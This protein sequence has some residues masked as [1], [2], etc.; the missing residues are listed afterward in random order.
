MA[1]SAAAR[2]SRP[3]TGPARTA[4]RSGSCDQT[5]QPDGENGHTAMRGA[6]TGVARVEGDDSPDVFAVAD[7]SDY[8]RHSRSTGPVAGSARAADFLEKGAFMQCHIRTLA[9][10]VFVSAWWCSQVFAAIVPIHQWS[11]E[12]TGITLEDSVG[13]ADGQLLGAGGLQSGG[14]LTLPGG[15]SDSAAYGDLPNGLISVLTDV[16]FEGWATVGGA[17]IWARLFDFGSNSAGEITGPGGSGEGL[18]YIMSSASRGAFND[19]QRTA[20]SN[21]DPVGGSNGITD[22]VDTN[23]PTL[24]GQQFHFA[25]VFDADGG[26]SAASLSYYR[27]GAYIDGRSDIVTQLSNINDVNNWLGRSNWTG[28][29]NF[30][31]SYDEFRIYDVAMTPPMIAD[32]F[33]AGPDVDFGPGNPSGPIPEPGSAVIWTSLGLAGVVFRRIGRMRLCRARRGS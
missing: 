30:Q 32:S 27:D 3:T 13:G 14:T 11:F 12:G 26:G 31:G 21:R 25:V 2:G 16:T 1:K 5:A 20:V 29:E 6:N 23:V 7:A 8:S 22:D 33:A 28:D 18:D 15:T 19:Q 17:R 10:A 24:L 4:V 9:M